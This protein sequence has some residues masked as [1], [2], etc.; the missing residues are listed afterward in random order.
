MDNLSWKLSSQVILGYVK[1]TA[2]IDRCAPNCHPL[3]HPSTSFAFTPSFPLFHKAVGS[4]PFLSSLRP[5]VY[6][7]LE[8]AT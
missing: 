6:T 2:K 4:P 1:V 7:A 3:S 8:I 5:R